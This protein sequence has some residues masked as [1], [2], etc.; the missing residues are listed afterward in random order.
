MLPGF[1]AIFELDWEVSR[2]TAPAEILAEQL[3]GGSPLFRA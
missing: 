2:V 1:A 3:L